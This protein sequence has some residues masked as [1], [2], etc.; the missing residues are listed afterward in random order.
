MTLPNFLIIGASRSGTTSLY[1]YFRQHPD[2]YM[3]PVKEPMYYWP[4]GSAEYDYGVTTREA[5]ERLFDG[6]TTER[7]I[8]EASPQYLRGA[9]APERIAADL[10]GVRLIVSLRN[11]A[12][13]AYSS[14]LGR[15]RGGKE[16]RG[17]AEALRPDGYYCQ[18]SVY[19]PQL[20]R[21]F[22]RFDRARIKVIIFE[23]LAARTHEVLREL[24]E[25]LGVDPAFVADTTPQ[26]AGAVPKN[27][28]V[29]AMFWKIVGRVKRVV[30]IRNTG[31]AGRLHRRM[32]KKPE[33]LPAEIRGELL[34][35]FRDDVA[36]TSALIGRDLSPWLETRPC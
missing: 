35:Y 32:V 27:V 20:V 10:P 29:N 4:E 16:R 5:Y 34:D 12:D 6:V 23:D 18:T 14:Y 3:S 8:G 21:Y 24:Y 19:Y 25:F 22:E 31:I 13:R 15:L 11:P 26:N 1:A 28:T 7:A 9:T 30:P 17:V 33:P 36:R 2:I